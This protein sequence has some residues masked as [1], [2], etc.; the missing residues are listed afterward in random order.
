M[1]FS[2]SGF[3]PTLKRTRQV[4]RD[5]FILGLSPFDALS[6]GTWG[7]GTTVAVWNIPW[8]LRPQSI[9]SSPSGM[10]FNPTRKWQPVSGSENTSDMSQ[11]CQCMRHYIMSMSQTGTKPAWPGAPTCVT[12]TGLDTS[13]LSTF[14][15]K[16]GRRRAGNH[17]PSAAMSPS[18]LWPRSPNTVP[19]RKPSSNTPSSN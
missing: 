9:Q 8:N 14:A 7:I 16:K 1:S 19:I 12:T 5:P 11:T 18:F 13:Q 17:K 15:M 6:Q 3:W 4:R 2:Y 10:V